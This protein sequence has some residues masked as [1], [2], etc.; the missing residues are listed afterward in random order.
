MV[1]T[2]LPTVSL[3]SVVST[4]SQVVPELD[5]LFGG[6]FVFFLGLCPQHLEISRPGTESELQLPAY[7]K[8][9]AM[10]D[11]SHICSLHHSL[12]QCWIFNLL[13]EA[14]DRTHIFIDTSWVHNLL[15]H[16]GNSNFFFLDK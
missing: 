9:T 2:K 4:L 16:N 3:G 11:P 8:D 14:R 5:L 1:G 13:S 15:S 6:F 10:P 7:I 12:W